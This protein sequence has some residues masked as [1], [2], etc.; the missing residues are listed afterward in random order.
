MK[1]KGVRFNLQEFN[2]HFTE[3]IELEHNKERVDFILCLPQAM[4]AY[5]ITIEGKEMLEYAE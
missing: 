5:N 1:Q 2:T 3:G 4:C